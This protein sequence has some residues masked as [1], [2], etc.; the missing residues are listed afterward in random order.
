MWIDET[1]DVYEVGIVS[2]E[3]A[4]YFDKAVIDTLKHWKFAGE[5]EKYVGEI[6]IKFAYK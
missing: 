6:E 3:P 1:G 5:G 4:H 2:A